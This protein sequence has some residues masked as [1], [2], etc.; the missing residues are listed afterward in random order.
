MELLGLFAHQA[1]VAL[2]LLLAARRAHA[3]LGE[4][5]DELGLVARVAA[6]LDALPPERREA[7]VRLLRELETLLRP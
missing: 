5:D 6:N 2:E 1:A 4:A 3:A 7:G